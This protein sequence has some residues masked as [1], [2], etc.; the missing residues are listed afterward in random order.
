MTAIPP[1][2]LPSKLPKATTLGSGLDLASP[3]PPPSLPAFAVSEDYS[4]FDLQAIL[5]ARWFLSKDHLAAQV[6]SAQRG[7]SGDFDWVEFA[8]PYHTHLIKCATALL[9]PQLCSMKRLKGVLFAFV[10]E[11][12]NSP[13]SSLDKF[14]RKSLGRKVCP[15]LDP[16]FKWPPSAG[17]KDP[18]SASPPGVRRRSGP[19]GPPPPAPASPVRAIGSIAMAC[20]TPPPS[21]PTPSP[22]AQPVGTPQPSTPRA[23][24]PA[25]SSSVHPTFAPSRVPGPSRAPPKRPATFSPPP[26]PLVRFQPESGDSRPASPTPVPPVCSC[27]ADGWITCRVHLTWDSSP[28]RALPHA[29]SSPSLPYSRDRLFPVP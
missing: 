19:A 16:S 11:V 18:A 23:L 5:R 1:S 28:L 26:R 8:P 7:P 2:A 29:L 14:K 20:D 10:L 3:P 27:R 22:H 24:D 13:A 4:V 9:P 6:V 15:R 17:D 12:L 25:P 21:S